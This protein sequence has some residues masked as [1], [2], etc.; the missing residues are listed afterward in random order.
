MLV[1]PQLPYRHAYMLLPVSLVPIGRGSSWSRDLGYPAR[2][3]QPE[4]EASVHGVG[5]VVQLQF[6][7]M[8]CASEAGHSTN[9]LTQGSRPLLLPFEHPL[10]RVHS[11]AA[12]S[13][14]PAPADD[15]P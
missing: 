8:F 1:C 12:Q 10:L 5:N 9:T 14:W 6:R 15:T 3:E 13:S 11:Q 7:V 2:R 4:Q